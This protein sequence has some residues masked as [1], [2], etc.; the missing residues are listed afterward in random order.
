MHGL[1]VGVRVVTR[2]GVTKKVH[3][4]FSER[5]RH[6]VKQIRSRTTWMH[7]TV[8]RVIGAKNAYALKKRKQ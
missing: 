6:A 4:F 5:G 7:G 2:N 3:R 8:C 1:S